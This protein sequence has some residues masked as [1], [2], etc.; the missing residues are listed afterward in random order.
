MRKLPLFH[1]LQDSE[2]LMLINACKI[3][4]LIEGSFL[5]REGDRGHELYILL[6]GKMRIQTDEIGVMGHIRPGDI[7]GEMGVV[8]NADRTATIIATENSM[9]FSIGRM[10]LEG[11]AGKAPRISYLIMRNIANVVSDRLATTNKKVE[12]L[13]SS[14]Y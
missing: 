6:N 11:L 14:G 3:V 7:V 8:R 2:H 4:K 10:D 13:I 9:L 12:S 5:F 1:G